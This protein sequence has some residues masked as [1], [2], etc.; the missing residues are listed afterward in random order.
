MNNSQTPVQNQE[1][2]KEIKKLIS[3]VLD[4]WKGILICA[5][6]GI[7][8]AFLALQ[9]VD[10]KYDIHAQILIEDN[11]ASGA[12]SSLLGGTASTMLQDFGGLVGNTTSNVNNE[13]AVIESRDLIESVVRMMDLNISYYKL[14]L[15]GK[16]EMFLETPFKVKFINLSDS[17]TD[18]VFFKVNV[19]NGNRLQITSDDLT[20]DFNITCKTN[21]TVHTEIGK[22][23]ISQTAVPLDSTLQYGFTVSSVDQVVDDFINK[24]LDVEINDKLAT[25]MDITLKSNIAAKGETTLST[26]INEYIRKNLSDK[27]II[28]DSTMSF[29]SGRVAL[30]N[31]DLNSIEQNIQNFKQKNN[32][33]DIEEQ[34]KVVIDKSSDYYKQLNDLEVQESVIDASLQY[35]TDVHNNKRPAPSITAMQD[36]NFL[37]LLQKYNTLEVQRDQL[38]LSN[39]NEN[40]RVQNIDVQLDNLRTDLI[41]SLSNQKKSIQIA[42]SRLQAENNVMADYIKGVPAQEKIFLD[43][44][45]QQEVKQALYLYLL[46]K[47]EETAIAKSS[48]IA[49]ARVIETPKSDFKPY[50]P[51]KI[52]FFAGGLILGIGLPIGIIMLKKIFTN[53]VMSREDIETALPGIPIVSEISH[54]EKT[55][56]TVIKENERSAI[57]EQF[58]AF[59]TNLRFIFGDKKCPVLLL[60]SSM[61]GEGKSF[62]AINLAYVYALTG[63]K[64]LLMELDLRKPKVS[65]YLKMSNDIGFSNYIISDMQ[66]SDVIKRTPVNENV[67]LMSSGSIPPNPVELLINPKVKTLFETLKKQFDLIIIDTPPVGLVTDSQEIAA[68]AD[69]NLYVIRHSYTFKNQLEF[70]KQLKDTGKIKDLYLIINDVMESASNR[71]GYGYGYGYG[72]YSSYGYGNSDKTKRKS[73]LK[74]S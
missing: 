68:Y 16:N 22:F 13:L 41:N 14:G 60:T 30:L 51:N 17:L 36:P 38:S 71:Y 45:R 64:V 4:Y 63:K 70:I 74:K 26:L 42:K 6:A 24:K 40:P 20:N 59:R 7:L 31:N 25:Y 1:K 18:K 12:S 37:A 35:V 69:V 8:L 48:N 11:P 23:Y 10:T 52:L 27:N 29:I 34:S 73:F 5:F 21:D 9:V 50:F 15:F 2:N 53:R 57:S 58:R 55:E 47:N 28:L 72:G 46:E 54:S 65:S 44:S 62:I 19:L 3:L 39:T 66:L 49:S 61:S 67:Y 56:G 32:I 33:A 43:L